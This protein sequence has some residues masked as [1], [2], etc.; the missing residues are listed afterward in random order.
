VS[1]PWKHEWKSVTNIWPSSSS[2]H[3]VVEKEEAD[4]HVAMLVKHCEQLSK[5]VEQLKTLLADAQGVA[6]AWMDLA[7]K[8]ETGTDKYNAAAY[9]AA[10]KEVALAGKIAQQNAK[11]MIA[12][13]EAEGVVVGSS[14]SHAF[15]GAKYSAVIL[16]EVAHYDAHGIEIEAPT[17]PMP[18][19]PKEAPSAL[20][21]WVPDAETLA[22]ATSTQAPEVS[23]PSWM[24]GKIPYAKFTGKM[25][26]VAAG[27]SFFQ[28]DP[29]AK[30]LRAFIL[31]HNYDKTGDAVV[32]SGVSEKTAEIA[33]EAL[34]LIAVKHLSA[35]SFQT[36]AERFLKWCKGAG[37][38]VELAASGVTSVALWEKEAP[39]PKTKSAIIEDSIPDY[40][41]W[42]ESVVVGGTKVTYDE[43]PEPPKHGTWIHYDAFFGTLTLH[44]EDSTGVCFEH[45][46]TQCPNKNT[47][48]HAAQK[49][50]YLLD[51]HG[52]HE[53]V[54]LFKEWWHKLI[55]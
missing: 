47:A 51:E 41:K 11:E 7:T 20:P 44:A 22:A 9:N 45:W 26:Q 8:K 30:K 13:L 2:H 27:K 5:R 53:A 12:Q 29:A 33:H 10:L 55:A 18:Y 50:K 4:A 43:G 1:G 54:V 52:K 3:L 39:K 46:T 32:C 36:V 37:L 38:K 15:D 31:T 23:E 35:F 42:Q 6:K 17:W 16:D 25:V 48:E 49:F 40:V 28:Y 21:R 14:A 19:A 34:E 24:P